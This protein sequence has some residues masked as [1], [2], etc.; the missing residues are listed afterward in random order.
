[1][2]G[3]L[4]EKIK[5]PSTFPFPPP[6]PYIPAGPRDKNS[7]RNNCSTFQIVPPGTLS[8]A[9]SRAP[10]RGHQ[11]LG[12]TR[13]VRLMRTNPKR[14]KK[15]PE[16]SRVWGTRLEYRAAGMTTKVKSGRRS[17]TSPDTKG[18]PRDLGYIGLAHYCAIFL[19]SI[20]QLTKIGQSWLQDVASLWG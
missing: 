11:G 2:L 12:G 9:P 14:P 8:T 13:T 17:V 15:A 1:M 6:S 3:T 19:L 10:V 4:V 16:M 18:R 5:A 20:G 7:L